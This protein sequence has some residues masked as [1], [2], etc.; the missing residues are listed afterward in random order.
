VITRDD[1]RRFNWPILIAAVLL[2]GLGLLF[3]SSAS[4]RSGAEGTGAYAGYPLK[5]ALWLGIGL[6]AF[7][8]TVLVPYRALGKQ[9]WTAYLILLA[10][11][12]LVLPFGG[13]RIRGWFRLGPMRMQPSEFMKVAY[14]LAV[15]RCLTYT[16]RHRRWLGL[17]LPF[18][19]AL[20]PMGLILKQPDLGTALVF[21]PV[22][23]AVLAA[24]G[25]RGRH[26]ATIALLGALA[27]PAAWYTGLVNNYQKARVLGFVF[28][29]DPERIRAISDD[30][31]V[32]FDTYQQTQSVLTIGSGGL[33][34]RGWGRG[35]QTRYD[36]LPEDHTDFIFSV[37]AEESG[38]LGTT[39]VM[40]LFLVIGLAGLGIARTARE[41]F[42][43]LVAIGMVAL[44]ETQVIIN[45]AVALG[46]MPV[47]GITLPFVSYGGSSLVTSFVAV[48]LIV[49]VGMRPETVVANRDD[50]EFDD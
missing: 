34:G 49:N 7:A 3:I 25:A 1:L 21:L 8:V 10:L 38:F 17:A 6:V 4:Y 46:L 39:L 22:L 35:T 30:L 27:L 45:L 9:A 13:G 11:L 44:V 36:F 31:G 43:R 24:A 18:V 47:T 26:L 37:I 41:P 33:V 40:V 12:V 23:F 29:N 14:V 20:V 15:A 19:V 32:R 48:G 5:Q 2:A 16:D 42:G 50:F 28:R